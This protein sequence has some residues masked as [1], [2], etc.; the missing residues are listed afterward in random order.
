MAAKLASAFEGVEMSF[1]ATSRRAFDSRPLRTTPVSTRG[2]KKIA[3]P[4][5]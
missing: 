5:V 4:V 1:R 2:A 3:G